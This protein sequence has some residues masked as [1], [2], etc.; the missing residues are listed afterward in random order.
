MIPVFP[1]PYICWMLNLSKS[2]KMIKIIGLG[3][4]LRGDD[5][6]GPEIIEILEAMGENDAWQLIDAG[7]DAF[8]VLEHLLGD[9]PV[10]LIDCADMKIAPGGVKMFT[11]EE[12]SLAE[13][14]KHVSLHGFGF[15]EVYRMARQLGQCAPCKIIGVQPR[16]VAFD[17]ELSLEVK[18]AIPEILNLINREA[19]IH[20][21]ESTY[22]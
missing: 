10:L 15:A 5:A 22:H 17:R 4:A 6:I 20:E 13:I 9:T 18:K 19:M 21:E 3:N 7:A 1:V 2:S 14:S 11:V 8:T 16:E 12:A